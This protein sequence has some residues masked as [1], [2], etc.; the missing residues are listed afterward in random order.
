VVCAVSYTGRVHP[1][2]AMTPVQPTPITRTPDIALL[3]N[4]LVE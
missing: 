1:E 3:T 4:G 2:M